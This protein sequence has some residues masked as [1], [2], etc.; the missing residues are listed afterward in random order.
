MRGDTAGMRLDQVYGTVAT[1]TDEEL[2]AFIRADRARRSAL[3]RAADQLFLGWIVRSFDRSQL[4]EARSNASAAIRQAG[5]PEPHP[6]RAAASTLLPPLVTLVA[7]FAAA[8]TFGT[9]FLRAVPISPIDR[10]M[11]GE[12]WVSISLGTAAL[13]AALVSHGAL[14]AGP[15]DP[16][17]VFGE[18]LL[19]ALRSLY[20]V[21]A[22]LALLPLAFIAVV[23]ALPDLA[24]LATIVMVVSALLL[25]VLGARAGMRA[26]ALNGVW[27]PFEDAA[28][29]AVARGHISSF[30]DYLLTLPLEL[31]IRSSAV[32]A[33]GLE[34]TAS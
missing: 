26:R 4:A 18:R 2:R 12:G 1:L 20:V 9:M 7:V 13:L 28:L 19:G 30:D 29:A 17:D 21:M 15:R 32:P 25:I 14:R 3:E 34:A 23:V 33:G 11:L 22:A 27:R 31:A 6:I 5:L 10:G 8:I 24:K 16:A